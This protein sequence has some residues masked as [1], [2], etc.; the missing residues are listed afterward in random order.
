MEHLQNVDEQTSPAILTQLS[1]ALGE[2]MFN[3]RFRFC[4]NFKKID[5]LFFDGKTRQNDA[6]MN[7]K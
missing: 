5:S 7:K 3:I 4:E 1:L 6:K 2:V